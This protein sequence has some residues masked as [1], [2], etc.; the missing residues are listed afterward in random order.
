MLRARLISRDRPEDLSLVLRRLNL[1]PRMR[2]HLTRE[3]GYAHVLVT[4]GRP[5]YEEELVPPYG[6]KEREKLPTWTP[7]VHVDHPGEVLLSGSRQQFDRLISLA[8]KSPRTDGLARV[9]EEVLS[10][11]PMTALTLSGRRFEWGARTYLMGVVNVTPDSFSDGGSLPDADSAV[12][13]ALKLVDAGADI[14][15]VGGEST[16]PGSLPVSADEE[17]SRVLKV[18]EGI[19]RRSTVPIS[20]DTMKAAVAKE[21]LKAG[22][23]LI[24]DVTGFHADPA[25]AGVVAAAGAACCLMHTQGMPRTMQ[26]APRYQDVVAEVMDYLEEGM[27]TATEAGIPRG[28]I[29]LDPGIGFGKTLEHNLFLLRRLEELRGLGQPLLVGTSRKSFLGKLAGGK[30]PQERLAATLGSVAAMAVMGGAD[31]VRVHDVGEA[32][33]AL[34]V[35]D[36]IRRARGGGDLYGG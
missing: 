14:V 32:R 11:T 25:L 27:F 35:A 29:L 20:V 30:G 31:V 1:S 13:H 24:N 23:H 3:L 26:E 19:K 15:D 2:E 36:A 34:A 5:S 16:R 7:G 28:R 18:V 22:A 12:E 9:L 10:P 4:G 6:S 21:A 33:D 17:L 8:R